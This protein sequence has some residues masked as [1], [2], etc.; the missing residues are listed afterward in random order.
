[1]FSSIN[2]KDIYLSN[3][4]ILLDT[5]FLKTICLRQVLLLLFFISSSTG[6]KS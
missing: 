3:L 1:M 6:I 4:L 5:D 2:E